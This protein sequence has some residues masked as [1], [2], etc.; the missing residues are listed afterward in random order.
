MIERTIRSPFFMVAYTG[1]MLLFVYASF[2]QKSWVYPLGI[3]VLIVTVG[4][5]LFLIVHNL[6]HPE[7]RIKLISFIPYEFNEEDEGQQ[8]VTNRACRKV[9]IF[10]YFAIPYSA[11]LMVLFPY[12]PEVPLLILFL[13]ASTQYTIYW[14]ET[15]RYLK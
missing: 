8:W 15:R 5:F 1:L 9:Y 13:L 12:F 3:V 11:L 2:E 7:R 14:Y 6:R 4:L 10:F